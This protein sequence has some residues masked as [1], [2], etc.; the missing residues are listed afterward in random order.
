MPPR[1]PL[2]VANFLYQHPR[3]PITGWFSDRGLQQLQLPHAD[4]ETPKPSLLHSWVNDSRTRVLSDALER[5]FAGVRES[6][7]SVPIDDTLGTEFQRR[8]WSASREIAWGET[9]SYGE[10]TARIG[11]DKGAARAVG[12]ALGSN[13]IAIIVPCH[14]FQA[15]NGNLTGFAAGIAWKQ[16]LRA[17]E[18]PNARD[19]WMIQPN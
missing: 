3:G 12:A 17:L 6:F 5:Y 19:L 7:D 4:R 11:E 8:V 14:R 15:A 10:L 13:P 1:P 18:N 16:E 9:M 2:E